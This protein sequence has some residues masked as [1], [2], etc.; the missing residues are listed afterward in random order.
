MR[1]LQLRLHHLWD[2]NDDSLLVPWDSACRQDLQWCLV[3]GRLLLGISLTQVHPHLDFWS[4]ASDMGWGAHLLGNAAYVL[5]S[6]EEAILSINARE[7]LAV[8]KGFLQFEHLLSNS[9]VA[10]FSDNSTALA[11]LHKLGGT[12]LTILMPSFSVLINSTFLSHREK[13]ILL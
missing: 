12:R 11:Y 4:D 6:P 8:E 10:L 13:E 2:R 9:T 3:P 1:S 7:L 5:W